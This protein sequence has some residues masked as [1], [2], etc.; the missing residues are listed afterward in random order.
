MKKPGKAIRI[1]VLA[2]IVLPASL[3]CEGYTLTGHVTVVSLG[4]RSDSSNV[5]VWLNPLHDSGGEPAEAPAYVTHRKYELLQKHKQFIPHV[6]VVPL[7]TAVEFPNLDPFFHNVFSLFDGKR[8]DLGL[9]EA[10]TTRIVRFDRQ[11]ICYI[12]CNIHPEMSA[13]VI[14]LKTPYYGIS[15]QAG[16]IRIPDVPSGHYVMEVWQERVLPENLKSLS[17]EV[18]VSEN[19]V[20]LGTLRLKE[21]AGLLMVHKNKYGRD[22]DN[23]NPPSPF[24]GQP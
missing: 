6:L 4:K 13:V 14:V 24:Y 5:I 11:G 10:G 8:F 16:E 17:R 22:Y 23:P 9:Y 19:S 7:G 20:S 21:S 12:F 1:V 3:W 2:M 18:I 15:D